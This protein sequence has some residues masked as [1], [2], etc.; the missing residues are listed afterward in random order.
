MKVKKQIIALTTIACMGLTAGG[1]MAAGN[2]F[3][4]SQG[5]RAGAPTKQCVQWVDNNGDGLCDNRGSGLN[6]GNGQ[7][8]N[9]VDNDGDGICDN[10]GSGLGCGQGQGRK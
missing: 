9:F 2:G 8:G 3:G 10:R 7:G 6:G 4:Q 5:A 1:V